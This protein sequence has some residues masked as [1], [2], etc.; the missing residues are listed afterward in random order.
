MDARLELLRGA[1][2]EYAKRE[3]VEVIRGSDRK[4][5]VKIETKAKFPGKGDDEREALELLLKSAR[6]WDELSTLDTFALARALK[7]ETLDPA[8]ISNL[9][10]FITT[11]ESCRITLSYL[12]GDDE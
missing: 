3:G 10:K 11:E 12:K 4:L 1:I 6:A 2:I 7:N 5:K 8:L 9:R